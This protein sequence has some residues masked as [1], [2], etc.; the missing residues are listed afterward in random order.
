METG[1]AII[2]YPDGKVPSFLSLNGGVVWTTTV[3]RAARFPTP[4]EAH[5][6]ADGRLNQDY[7]VIPHVWTEPR[8]ENSALVGGEGY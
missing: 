7:R 6:F 3:Q 1:F 5:E 8:F 2:K 4:F